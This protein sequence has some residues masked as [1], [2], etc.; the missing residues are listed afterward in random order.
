VQGGS[1]VLVPHRLVVATQARA[2]LAAQRVDEAL[3]TARRAVNLPGEDVRS[4]EV[5]ERVLADALAA[6]GTAVPV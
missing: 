6:A 5:A 4:R 1:V 3:A 2:L